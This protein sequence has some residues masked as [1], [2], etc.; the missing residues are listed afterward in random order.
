LNIQGE[1]KIGVPRQQVFD[2]IIDP[3]V[4]KKCIPGCE[5]LQ[6][7]SDT[8]YKAVIKASIGPVRAAFKTSMELKNL[9]PPA[10][11]TLAGEGKGG[12]AG[13]GRGSADITLDESDGATHL[14][15]EADL[16]VGGKLAQVGSRLVVGVTRKM[17]DEFFGTFSSIL[18]AGAEKVET[19]EDKLLAEKSAI[20]KRVI[21][22]VGPILMLLLVYWLVTK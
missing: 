9:N 17:A 3:E 5:E 7:V 15:Y 8:Q 22:I 13:F 20:R 16:K 4:L 12:V 19:E 11:F 21:V 2:A 18:D 10:S 1:Y 6:Q 14:H